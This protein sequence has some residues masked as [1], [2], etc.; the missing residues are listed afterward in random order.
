MRNLEAL[1]ELK[2]ALIELTRDGFK[3][4]ISTDNNFIYGHV[5]T[6]SDNV[7]T[8]SLD[9]FGVWKTSLK[10]VPTRKNGSGCSC[11]E[12]PIGEI[13]KDVI[14]KSEIE[15]LMFAR[16]LNAKLYRN[17]IDWYNGLYN[18]DLIKEVIQK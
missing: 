7:I 12:N 3:C 11:L 15:G 5:V 9:Y 14:L 6:P 4:Y 8:I 13:T 1:N 10:Y 17:S 18:K 16:K 2:T